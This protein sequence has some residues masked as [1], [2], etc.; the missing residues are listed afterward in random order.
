MHKGE[1]KPIVVSMEDRQGG[2]KHITRVA[3]YEPFGLDPEELASV[4]Q[5][6]FQVGNSRLAYTAV[7]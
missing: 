2:R 6:K 7:S 3:H 4:L 1:L 5:R